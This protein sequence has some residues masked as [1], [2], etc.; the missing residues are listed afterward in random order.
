MNALYC[1]QK[2][3]TKFGCKYGARLTLR[4]TSFRSCMAWGNTQIDMPGSRQ[5][6]LRGDVL[7]VV[8]TIVD[9]AA[10]ASI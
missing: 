2:T 3:A 8:M 4:H 6:Q 7:F 5:Q 9:M 10:A 1:T